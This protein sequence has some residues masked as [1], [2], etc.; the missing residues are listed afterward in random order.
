VLSIYAENRLVARVSTCGERVSDCN[1]RH[2]T[3]EPAA[4]MSCHTVSCHGT[5]SREW[6][7][8]QRTGSSGRSFLSFCCC[9]K[10]KLAYLLLESFHGAEILQLTA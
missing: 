10:S 8:T 4:V 2:E 6:S 5:P 9:Y 7:T 3:T 1:R